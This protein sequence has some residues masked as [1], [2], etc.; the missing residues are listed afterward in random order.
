MPSLSET[1]ARFA[2]YLAGDTGAL[3]GLLRPA[4]TANAAVHR[5][6]R[7]AAEREALR[8]CYPVVE[9]LV[10]EACFQAFARRY[11][12]DHPPVR[13]T[14][15]GYGARFADWLAEQPEVTGMAWL[16]DVARLEWALQRAFHAPDAAP[17]TPAALGRWDV[18]ELAGRRLPLHPSVQRLTSPWPVGRI[19][20][21]NQP[22]AE[23]NARVALDEGGVRLVVARDPAG[24][25][26][27]QTHGAGGWALLD[28]VAAGRPLGEACAAALEA[29]SELALPTL[30]N[31][32]VAAGVFLP[33]DADASPST[34]NQS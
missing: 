17:L 34:E 27:W 30:L 13:G 2:A 33:P 7:R 26:G 9:R 4:G 21:V 11:G 1:Q 32:L 28:A 14:L 20:S 25:V 16:A 3:D 24:A 10:G 19:W 8:A 6:N 23:A 5:N 15:I 18:A 31:G 12:D 22:D 29:E